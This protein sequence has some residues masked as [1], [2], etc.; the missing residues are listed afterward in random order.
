MI[1]S[2]IT[3]DS[4]HVAEMSRRARRVDR[5][6]CFLQT[7]R[8]LHRQLPV[9][10]DISSAAWAG[11]AD[12]D[13]VTVFGV[14][15]AAPLDGIGMPWLVATPRLERVAVPFLRLNRG[16]F[17]QMKEG[18]TVLTNVVYDENIAAIR[19]LRWL[20]F[21]IGEP[22]PWGHRRAPFRRFQWRAA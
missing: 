8:R 17:E 20:G 10:F 16:Y 4:R 19:W 6:E 21:E 18:Y 1:P 13:L 12:D 9:T 15:A 5:L 11:Y 2:V 22:H 7:G 3:A 14:A